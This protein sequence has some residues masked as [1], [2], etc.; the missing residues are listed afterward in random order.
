MCICLHSGPLQN[1][2]HCHYPHPLPL[3]ITID[4]LIPQPPKSQKKK[5]PIKL[6]PNHHYSTTN[7]TH[8]KSNHKLTA[9]N[10]QITNPPPKTKSQTHQIMPKS[11]SLHK[12]TTYK[13]KSKA[14]EKAWRCGS[15]V[16]RWLGG[17]GD[18]LEAWVRRGKK[19]WWHGSGM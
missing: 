16:G 13:S 10:P 15:S 4:H 2:T 5:K 8:P 9:H 11:E 6:I 14:W 19:A 17:V 3:A 7:H 12:S 1:P 18:G